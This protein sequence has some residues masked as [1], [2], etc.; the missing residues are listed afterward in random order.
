MTAPTSRKPEGPEEG[1]PPFPP[2]KRFLPPEREEEEERFLGCR[3]RA[4]EGRRGPV[5]GEEEEGVERP[6]W[7]ARERARLLET[8]EDDWTCEITSARRE[9]LKSPEEEPGETVRSRFW[10]SGIGRVVWANILSRRLALRNTE[11]EEAVRAAL[12]RAAETEDK[13]ELKSAGSEG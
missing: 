9:E 5:K 13:A 11:H 2:L 3:P 7:K 4:K 12:D 10:E 6:L 1:A 8:C